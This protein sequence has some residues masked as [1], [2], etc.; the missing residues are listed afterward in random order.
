MVNNLYQI[1]SGNYAPNFIG[2]A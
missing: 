1:Y 2:I